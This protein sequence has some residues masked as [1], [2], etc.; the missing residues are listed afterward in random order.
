MTKNFV[1]TTDAGTAGITHLRAKEVSTR[2][3]HESTQVVRQ[4]ASNAPSGTATSSG[5]ATPPI[6]ITSTASSNAAAE[7]M[8]LPVN[9]RTMLFRMWKEVASDFET[10]AVDLH[11]QNGEPTLTGTTVTLAQIY[12]LAAAGLSAQQIADEFDGAVSS[13]QVED[14]FRFAAKI[15]ALV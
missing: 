4:K 11:T 10:I 15:V 12:E 13:E 2:S 5:Y 9:R 8:A 7:A 14:A 1:G 3:A 6:D